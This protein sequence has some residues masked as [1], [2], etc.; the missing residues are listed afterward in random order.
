MFLDVVKIA[1][2]REEKRKDKIEIEKFY[3]FKL[4]A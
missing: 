4:L 1:I 3:F 2:K